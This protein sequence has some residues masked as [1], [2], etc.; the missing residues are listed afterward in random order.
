MVTESIG[1]RLRTLRLAKSMTQEDVAKRIGIN[2]VTVAKYETE[3]CIPRPSVLT[4]LCVLF[5]VTEKYLRTGDDSVDEPMESN[6]G[7][8]IKSKPKE[9][10]ITQIYPGTRAKVKMMARAA[11]VTIPEA[12]D[13]IVEYAFRNQV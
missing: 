13:Q 3:R 9:L 4:D 1:T 2:R 8:R 7:F 10:C 12:L 6:T 5:G 11:G